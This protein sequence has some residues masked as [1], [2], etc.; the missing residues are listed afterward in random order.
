MTVYVAILKGRQPYLQALAEASDQVKSII[1]P[2][3]EVFP[4]RGDTEVKRLITRLAGQIKAQTLADVD[5]CFDTQPLASYFGP[6]GRSEALRRLTDELGVHAFRPV[7]HLGDTGEDLEELR[8]VIADQQMGLCLRIPLS[9]AHNLDYPRDLFDLLGLVGES[10]ER[11]DVI[12]ECGHCEAPA[13]THR[14]LTQPMRRLLEYE[15]HTLTIAAGSFPSPK[16][17]KPPPEPCIT[18]LPRAE[19]ELWCRVSTAWRTVDYGDYGIDHASAPPADGEQPAPN[20]RYASGQQWCLYYWPKDSRGRHS[21]FYPLCRALMRSP[22]W[23]RSGPAFSW[24]DEQI[25][26]AAQEERGPGGGAQWKA[27]ALSHYL[28]LVT[29]TL[30]QDAREEDGYV[31]MP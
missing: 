19:S 9:F 2:L 28:A 21:T 1:R 26:A 23:P 27:F 24:G 20:L 15:W 5:M 11:T 12:L 16:D 29:S 10:P 8:E 7:V 18:R 17:F 6:S 4:R 13:E 14:Q 31:S 3:I 30:Q 22:E 25:A